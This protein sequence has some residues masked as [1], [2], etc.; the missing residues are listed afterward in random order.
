MDSDT[1]RWKRSYKYIPLGA[2]EEEIANSGTSALQAAHRLMAPCKVKPPRYEFQVATPDIL[3]LVSEGELAPY[4]EKLILDESLRY[5]RVC[6]ELARRAE[7]EEPELALSLLR[8]AT[9]PGSSGLAF[10]SHEAYKQ[11]W[12]KTGE[13]GDQSCAEWQ[14][15]I[16][17]VQNLTGPTDRSDEDHKRDV[18]SRFLTGFAQHALCHAL[19][20]AAF[21]ISDKQEAWNLTV[22]ASMVALEERLGRAEEA[23]RLENECLDLLRQL[24]HWSRLLDINSALWDE[25]M[26]VVGKSLVPLATAVAPPPPDLEEIQATLSRVLD[27]KLGPLLRSMND[28]QGISHALQDRVDFIV[29]KLIDLDQRSELT[30]Q[31]ISQSARQEPDYEEATRD[32]ATSLENR[33]G[34]MWRR[35]TPGSSEDLVDAEYIYRHCSQ[36]GRGW[37]MAVLGYC[38]TAERELQASYRTVRDQLVPASAAERATIQTLGDLIQSVEGLA[39]R[40]PKS[41]PVP[42]GLGAFLSSVGDLW[43]LNSIRKKATHPKGVSQDEVTWARQALLGNKSGALLA[44]IVA[45]RLEQ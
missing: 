19:L 23:S 33:L 7:A 36:W 28:V 2:G 13:I 22:K 44:T 38:T 8:S 17:E 5:A 3:S 41:K 16:G 18:L 24:L 34:D 1:T 35:L 31:R 20:Q 42:P 25:V 29:E 30:W 45:V 4:F 32:I 26:G 37:R 27:S 43:R 14:K 11:W 12:D 9:L 10:E 40:R 39:A 6:K 15:L 21:V